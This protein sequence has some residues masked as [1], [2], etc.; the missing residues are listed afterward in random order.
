LGKENEMRKSTIALL[1]SLCFVGPLHGAFAADTTTPAQTAISAKINGIAIAS[2]GSVISL[3]GAVEGIAPTNV[4]FVWTLAREGQDAV[5]WETP[6]PEFET[7]EMEARKVSVTLKLFAKDANIQTAKPLAVASKTIDFIDP[8]LQA[9]KVSGP[10]APEVGKVQKYIATV[11]A[12]WKLT[13]ASNMTYRAMW[14]LPDKTTKTAVREANGTYVLEWVPTDAQRAATPPVLSFHQFV[15]GLAGVNSDAQKSMRTDVPLTV[16]KYVWPSFS[17]EKVCDSDLSGAK[18]KL[19]VKDTDTHTDAD[20]LP[21]QLKYEWSFGNGLVGKASGNG[22][23]TASTVRP[24][25]YPVGVTISDG[26]GNSSTIQTK[27]LATRFAPYAIDLKLVPSNQYERVPVTYRVRAKVTGGQ[28]GDKISEYDLMVNGQRVLDD[29]KVLPKA[30]VMTTPGVKT[31]EFG[32]KSGYGNSS[33]T[34]TKVNVIENKVPECESV[35]AFADMKSKSIRY[36]AKKC[37]DPDGKV[38]AWSWTVNGVQ[39]KTS[40]LAG[41]TPILPDVNSYI[42]RLGMMD[43]S[44]GMYEVERVVQVTQ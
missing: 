35:E 9:A 8:K 5:T 28:R 44:G 42:V 39:Q 41:S 4:R 36:A 3:G 16:K 1:V 25:E 34:A 14:I 43:D 15:D 22:T 29:P 38:K 12:P 24:G 33:Y 13:E 11:P 2:V 18:C 20:I 10:K 19:S 32:V 7:E 37:T 21:K 23:A 31:I 40:G 30:I 26:L 6:T 27:V 17:M